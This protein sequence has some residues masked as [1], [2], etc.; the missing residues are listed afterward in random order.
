[1]AA[2]FSET[3]TVRRMTLGMHQVAAVTPA[4]PVVV[5]AGQDPAGAVV[6]G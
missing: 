4:V 1:M 6:A 5:P 3:P 2:A